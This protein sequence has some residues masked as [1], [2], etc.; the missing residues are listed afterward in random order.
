MHA[1]EQHRPDVAEKRA[2]WHELLQGENTGSLVFLDESGANTQ[3]TRW[4]GRSLVGQRLVTHVPHGHYQTSTLIA[5]I[6]LEGPCAPW[7]FDGPMNGAMFLA[8]VKEGLVPVLKR[9]DLVI[10]D[11]L[12]T[13]KVLGVRE[14]IEEV[15]ARLMYLPPYSPDFN[16]IEN[17]WSKIKQ[18]LRSLAPRTQDELLDATRRAFDAISITDCYGFFSHACYAT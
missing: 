13:H 3:M 1:A 12:A 6:R 18:I 16:P 2:H 9:G 17:M 8:W 15:G 7:V 5:A 14:A 4:R 11:N 10:L